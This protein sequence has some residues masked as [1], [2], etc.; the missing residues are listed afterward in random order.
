MDT[1]KGIRRR[2]MDMSQ[3]HPNQG[4]VEGLPK[5]PRF[6]RDPKFKKLV[7]SIQDDPEMLELRE[8]I[9]YDTSD[10]R[11]FV[12]IGGNMRYEALRKLKYKTA[13]C[14]I[15]PHDFPMDKMRRI[16]LKD[17]S[18]FGETNFDDL[19]N[20]WKPEEIDAAAIDVP[21]IP[22]PEE[23]EEA[24]DDAYDVAGNTPKKAT[25]RT[26]DLYRLG[27]HRLICG[28]STKEEYLEA[29]MQDE[30]ADLL[31]TDPPYNVDYQA[32][33]KMKIANDHMADE[34]FVAFLTDTL[35]NASNSMKPGAAFY[36]WHADSQGFNFRT[37]VKN[38]GWETRQCLI[39]NK[40]SLVLGRQDYQWKHE[41]CQPAGTKVRTP[42]GEI[43]IE[44]LKDGDKV[45]SYDKYAGAI[46]GFKDGLTIKT[47][48]RHYTGDIYGIEVDDRKT[49]ATDNH[50]FTVRFHDAGRKIWCVYLMRRGTWWR[51]GITETYNSRGF[52]LKQR[53]RQ[54]NADEAWILKIFNTRAEAQCYE[55]IAA[56]KYGI[57]YTYW[58]VDSKPVPNGY[59]IRTKEQIKWIYSHFD[60]CKLRE[61]AEILLR[62]FGRRIEYPLITRENRV[63]HLSTR[64][65]TDVRACNIIPQIM[66]LPIPYDKYEGTHT[67]E[68]KPVTEVERKA[69]DGIVYSLQV[70]KYEH[71]IADG[72]VTHNC[73]YG[74]K[75]G[76]AHYFT[77]KRNLTTVMEQKL[78]IE[79]MSKAE[80][81]DLLTQLFGG[82]I[83]T[84]V[85][86]CDK[87]KKNP[88][89]PTMKPV[90]LIG[91][92]ISNSSRRKDIVLDIFGGSGTTL[93]AA[94]QLGRCCRM[95]EYE[96]IYVDVIIKRWEELTGMKAV[97]IG[98]INDPQPVQ[99]PGKPA[100]PTK[101]KTK[102]KEG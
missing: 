87:P 97:H 96:P 86:D 45:I 4:Q 5:N 34:N 10:E 57:P 90:P 52:G 73:L 39:W 30:Q 89:H 75:D 22:D 26:G 21:D 8:L 25:S 91:K 29:L 17:N 70:E 55:Q 24:K 20:E 23:E 94:E 40:N 60:A 76:A 6:I 69:Y 36:I 80:M 13:V 54:E 99:Q 27:N 38:I 64:V 43:S 92:L 47:A 41:P 12:I 98:N 14:K 9:V 88:D 50:R 100:E 18:S 58:E 72:I 101:T 63:H 11:G 19:I 31:V 51:V 49:W 78:D 37:A 53:M 3:L 32:K 2:E 95:I 16:V 1:T 35:Q 68:W 33:G 84:S 67:F 7:K 28:D 59:V 71:Y 62:A 79:N 42:T 83:P 85:I 102:Q 61:K 65:T 66:E 46:K 77:N 82:D 48:S 56:V 15:L 93:I 74:W 81:K 44:E